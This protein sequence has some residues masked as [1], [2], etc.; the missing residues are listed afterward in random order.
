MRMTAT[1]IVKKPGVCGGDACLIGTRFTVWGLV[2]SRLQGVT[3]EQILR[4][5]PSLSMDDLQAAWDYYERNHL[6]IKRAFWEN[7]VCMIEYDPECLPNAAID[8]G[9]D[10][11]FSNEEIRSAFAPPLPLS[12]LVEQYET[13]MGSDV[14]RGGM[15]LEM[16]DKTRSELV[17]WAFY[18]DADGTFEFK[19]YRSDVSADV[20]EWFRDEARRRLPH[21]RIESVAHSEHRSD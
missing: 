14:K 13:L 8:Q 21:I 1:Q 15:Y 11:G 7:S 3:D 16:W 4:A 20:G 17:L 5:H 18:S 2:E 12:R 6:E 9:R 19:R 10:L